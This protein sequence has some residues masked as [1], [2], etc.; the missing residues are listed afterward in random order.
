MN[1][2]FF[3]T[4]SSF[5]K[6]WD[7]TTP[8]KREITSEWK[9]TRSGQKR[10]HFEFILKDTCKQVLTYLLSTSPVQAAVGAPDKGPSALLNSRKG[11][12]SAQQTPT[13]DST[14]QRCKQCAQGD[15]LCTDRWR[16][17]EVGVFWT[18]MVHHR[19]LPHHNIKWNTIFTSPVSQNIYVHIHVEI[20][21]WALKILSLKICLLNWPSIVKNLWE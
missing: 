5:H 2:L 3:H 20:N 17:K 1:V 11:K 16:R 15:L 19:K 9:L 13:W 10:I 6:D 14:L 18:K 4:Y 21:C 12:R 7:E 8:A